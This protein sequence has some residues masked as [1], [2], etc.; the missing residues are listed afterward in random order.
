VSGLSPLSRCSVAS[1]CHST[2]SVRSV[3][4][5]LSYAYQALDGLGTGVG[6]LDE[7]DVAEFGAFCT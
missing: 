1:G 2:P 3:A 4:T 7:V 5:L 6:T